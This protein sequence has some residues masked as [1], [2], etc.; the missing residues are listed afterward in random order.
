MKLISYFLPYLLLPPCIIIIKICLSKLFPK[1]EKPEPKIQPLTEYMAVPLL[2]RYESINYRAMKAYADTQGL[3]IH[4]KVRLADLI[5]PQT[6]YNN[7]TWKSRFNKI[8]SKHVDFVICDSDMKVQVIVEL[9]DRSHE[10]ADRQERDKFV[11]AALIGAG[12]KIVHIRAFD[13]AGLESVDD[14]INPKVKI[15]RTNPTFDEWKASR[16]IEPE[17]SKKT[18]EESE[19]LP[20]KPEPIPDKMTFTEWLDYH[21]ITYE[22]W[23]KQHLAQISQDK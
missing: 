6:G 19:S 16:V 23:S 9:D 12:Y 7:K 17:I 20:E 10:R 5:T 3:T 21:G 11:D 13:N 15:D 8:S 18:L 4:V 14:V 22:E 1:E 2:T